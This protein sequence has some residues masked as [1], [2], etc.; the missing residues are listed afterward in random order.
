MKRR[1]GYTGLTRF[2]AKY[3]QLVAI[4]INIKTKQVEQVI[5]VVS[6]TPKIGCR[7]IKA[8]LPREDS[9]ERRIFSTWAGLL[10][11]EQSSWKRKVKRNGSREKVI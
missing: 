6:T 8:K 2:P 9:V 1:D 7:E 5:H 4:E 11:L 3:G 10:E